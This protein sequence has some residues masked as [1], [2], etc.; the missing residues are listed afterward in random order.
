MQV[1]RILPF[2]LLGF[3]SSDIVLSRNVAVPYL[4]SLYIEVVIVEQFARLT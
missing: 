3:S 4:P 1:L 2:E